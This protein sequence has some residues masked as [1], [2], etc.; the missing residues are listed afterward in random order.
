MKMNSLL[1]GVLC[2]TMAGS[3]CAAQTLT[4][5]LDAVSSGP[6]RFAEEEIRREAAAHG[7]S[8]MGTDAKAPADAIHIKL[9][10]G[11]PD[12]TKALSQGYGI[13]VQR[14]N[15]QRSITVRGADASGVM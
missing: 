4:L 6:G 10:V 12:G 5:T 2:C 1:L 14:E 3:A 9:T 8:V 7:I 13:R 15:G 11:T